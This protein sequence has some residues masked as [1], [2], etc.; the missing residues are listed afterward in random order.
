M[1]KVLMLKTGIVLISKIDELSS[2]LGEPDCMLKQPFEMIMNSMTEEY[3]LRPWPSF[4]R[5][6]EIMIHSDSILTIVDPEAEYLEK[7]Q[8][9]ISE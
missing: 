3:N 5:Q 7:Y 2:E 1:T 4:S 8:K 9:L 6:Q